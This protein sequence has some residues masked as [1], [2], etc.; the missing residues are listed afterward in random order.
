[1]YCIVCALINTVYFVVEIIYMFSW[2]HPFSI[3]SGP[4]LLTKPEDKE[5]EYEDLAD[6]ELIVCLS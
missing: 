1:M 5:D 6:G 2:H 4:V 3:F